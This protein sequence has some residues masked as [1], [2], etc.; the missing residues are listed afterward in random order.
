MPGAPEEPESGFG[1][2]EERLTASMD[3]IREATRQLGRGKSLLTPDMSSS[4]GVERPGDLPPDAESP[5]SRYVPS[6]L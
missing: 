5:Q 1:D 3:A 2:A 6:S 4:Q